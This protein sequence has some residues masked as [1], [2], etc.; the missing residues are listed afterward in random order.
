MKTVDEEDE[1]IQD[2]RCGVLTGMN[3]SSIVVVVVVIIIINYY[4]RL[5][6]PCS[7]KWVTDRQKRLLYA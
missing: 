2:G 4:V 3:S 7:T 6:N 5:I 1:D